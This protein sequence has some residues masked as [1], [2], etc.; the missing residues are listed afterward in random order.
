M[1]LGHVVLSMHS[2]HTL[3]IHIFITTLYVRYIENKAKNEG[4]FVPGSI[5]YQMDRDR[6]DR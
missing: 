1:I 2:Y 6:T 4:D 3:P 5:Y